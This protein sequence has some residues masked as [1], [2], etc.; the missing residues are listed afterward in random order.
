M[1]LKD[2]LPDSSFHVWVF[3][4]RE[5]GIVGKSEGVRSVCDGM[6]YQNNLP[7]LP[8]IACVCVSVPMSVPVV[9]SERWDRVTFL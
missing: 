6:C 3:E 7:L 1:E 9:D 8:I 5:N 2:R 4:V